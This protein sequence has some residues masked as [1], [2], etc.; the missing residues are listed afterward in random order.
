MCIPGDWEMLLFGRDFQSGR[1]AFA[2]R[3]QHR[4]EFHWQHV[5]GRPDFDR[6][7]ADYKAKLVLNNHAL[8]VSLHRHGEWSG[9]LTHG[10]RPTTSRFGRFFPGEQCLVEAVFLWPDGR[11]SRV[12]QQVLD[13]FRENP[14]DASGLWSWRAFG[15]RLQVSDKLNLRTCIAQPGNA[16]MVFAHAKD[17]LWKERFERMGM[18]THWLQGPVNEWLRRRIPAD[19]I[20]RRQSES[21]LANHAIAIVTGE[22]H[23]LGLRRLFRRRRSYQARAWICPGDG[24]LYCFMATRPT[25]MEPAG[26]AERQLTCCDPLEAAL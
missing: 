5:P 10:D 16:R 11:D 12:E 25:G 3:Y 4:L 19:V 13:S 7:L 17:V 18:V 8:Q 9:L 15:M 24:R 14:A 22:R 1:C 23:A 26:I 2:D 20:I 6:M 21:R